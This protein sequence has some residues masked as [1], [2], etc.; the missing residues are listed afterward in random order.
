MGQ[1]YSEAPDTPLLTGDVAREL[2]LSTERVRQLARENRLRTSK[3]AS[4]FLVF[5]R[6]SVDAYKAR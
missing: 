4:G 1:Q 3:T 6:Q 2:K 5:D